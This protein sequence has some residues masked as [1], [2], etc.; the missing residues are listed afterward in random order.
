MA[1]ETETLEVGRVEIG[2]AGLARGDVVHDLG[3]L[4]ALAAEGSAAELF[5]PCPTPAI[6]GVEVA[7]VS[8]VGCP[9]VRPSRSTGKAG[10]AES[11][12]LGGAPASRGSA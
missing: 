9:V 12:S 11:P 10:G 4:T 8:M 6:G 3:E 1:G 2:P 7:V 5:V